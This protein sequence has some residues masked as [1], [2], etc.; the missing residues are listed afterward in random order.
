MIYLVGI[1]P[2]QGDFITQE[3]F[4]WLTRQ[5]WIFT[6][7]VPAPFIARISDKVQVRPLDDDAAAMT[8]D[9][10][11][12]KVWMHSQSGTD[13]TLAVS[14]HPLIDDLVGKKI[15]QRA[16]EQQVD[17]QVIEGMSYLEPCLSLLG[18]D[19]NPQIVCLD[20]AALE[21]CHAVPF[22]NT[23]KVL[24][25]GILQ[26]DQAAAIQKLLSA[27]YPK[28]HAI[29]LLKNVGC[30]NAALEVRELGDLSKEFDLNARVFFYIPPLQKGHAMEDFQEVVAH[31]RAPEGCPWD[32][33]QTH[34]SL[35]SNLIE[36][37][38]EAVS[39]IDAHDMDG[40][41]EELGDVLLQVVLH[42]Q[43]ASEMGE[44]TLGDVIQ[45]ISAKLIRRHPH[46]FG[47]ADIK[48]ASGVIQNW[49]KIKAAERAG[50]ARKKDKGIL[51]G[52]P[53]SLP[54]LNQAQTI[55]ERAARVGFDW[56]EIE[57]VWDKVKEELSEVENAENDSD[58]AEELGDVLFALVNII[59][60]N[61]A[62][63]ETLLRNTNQKFRNRFKI[64]EKHAAAAGKR[65]DELS[66]EEM[67]RLWEQAKASLNAQN[68][69]P[70]DEG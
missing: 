61:K 47:N 40:L 33:E 14:G 30:R 51:D 60:W 35:R 6:H 55:Q 18:I 26:V 17:I 21:G 19:S 50:D 53:N 41:K 31:L 23:S 4:E 70:A 15:C 9:A 64:I 32:R 10:A 27:S 48:T 36:E 52:I 22:Q 7:S 13:V 25:G 38:Y 44:F 46:V 62:D 56:R 11:A 1:G 20:A 58:K 43:I 16:K 37:T 65:V 34:Q 69:S 49:E 68:H 54:A 2:G 5:P 28:D 42:A 59:R 66:F 57:P 8:I 29:T 3:A 67:D 12:E 63:A 45:G 24:I 39:A